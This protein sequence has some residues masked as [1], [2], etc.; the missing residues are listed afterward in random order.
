M[1]ATHGLHYYPRVTKAR[2]LTQH[3]SCVPF[4]MVST[5]PL[6]LLRHED[7][8]GGDMTSLSI[9]TMHVSISNYVATYTRACVGVPIRRGKGI[10]CHEP[11]QRPRGD[12]C[13]EDLAQPTLP[14]ISRFVL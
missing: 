2:P 8:G 3:A 13:L 6:A 14:D 10:G 12:T 9:F 5:V 11:A 1:S 7:I 4:I